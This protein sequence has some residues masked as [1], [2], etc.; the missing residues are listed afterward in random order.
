MSAIT[1]AL[2][3]PRLRR[4]LVLPIFVVFAWIVVCRYDLA[5]TRIL[6]PPLAVWE[7]AK[8][9]HESGELWA[10]L[11]ASL[12]RDLLGFALGTLA[13]TAVGGL[14]ALSRT[15]DRLFSPSFHA[16]KQVALFAWIPLMSVWLGVGEQAKVAFIALSAFY[17][18][19]VN[20]YEGV[21]S[22]GVEH[23]EVARVLR[24][25]RWQ[26]VRKVVL[27][28]AAPSL[29]A[30][31]HQALIYAWLGTLGAEYLLEPAPGI[32]SLMV[33]GRERFAMD[34]VLVGLIVSGLVGF[35]L[36]LLATAAEE[37]LL[38]WRVRGV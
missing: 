6:V 7:A 13:G 16:A 3:Q 10:H 27:P 2:V 34:V 1:Q 12:G 30:G 31:V 38:R 14:L 25:S 11:R 28:S 35:G 23:I 5:N 15:A 21:R 37:R 8:A 32:G 24:F 22:V 19:V 36:N 29:F 20:T 33:D 4:G 18:V 17:P 9:Q 26:V